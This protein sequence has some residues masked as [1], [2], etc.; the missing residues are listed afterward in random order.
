MKTIR[1]LMVYLFWLVSVISQ[2]IK[3]QHKNRVLFFNIFF[4]NQTL[5]KG[6]YK[7]SMIPGDKEA[8]I[9]IRHNTKEYFATEGSIEILSISPTVVATFNFEAK[10]YSDILENDLIDGVLIIKQGEFNSKSN[11]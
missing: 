10:T 9:F 4:E 3:I 1:L 5:R 2:Y 8:A 6:A 11:L 7:I